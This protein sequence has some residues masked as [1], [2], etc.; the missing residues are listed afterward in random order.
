MANNTTRAGIAAGLL[1]ALVTTAAE[2][3][4]TRP[5]AQLPKAPAAQ[6]VAAVPAPV[7]PQGT[8]PSAANTGAGLRSPDCFEVADQNDAALIKALRQYDML[9]P[10]ATRAGT[11][12][13]LRASPAGDLIAE[14]GQPTAWMRPR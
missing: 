12:V 14:K 7:T 13:R 6:P 1:L 10:T 11:P 4:Y 3:Q 8:Q 2:A 5:G 9:C